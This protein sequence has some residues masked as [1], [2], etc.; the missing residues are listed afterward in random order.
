L[1]SSSNNKVLHYNGSSPSGYTNSSYVG[2][3]NNCSLYIN[4]SN[5][6]VV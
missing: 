4:Y 2:M 5:T 3:T 6:P 1:D